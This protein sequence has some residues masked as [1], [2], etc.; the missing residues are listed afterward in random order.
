MPVPQEVPESVLSTTD[1]PPPPAQPRAG[2]GIMLQPAHPDGQV[3]VRLMFK[4][5][6][7]PV[8]EM[9]RS[10]DSGAPLS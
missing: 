3:N 7:G 9:A 5:C 8:P 1:E 2:I 6:G 10:H 4:S